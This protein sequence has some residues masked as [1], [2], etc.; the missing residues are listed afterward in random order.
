MRVIMFFAMLLLISSCSRETICEDREITPVFLKFTPADIDTFIVRKY[1]ANSAF[2][3]LLDS[4]IIVFGYSGYYMTHSD[5][6]MVRLGSG[7]LQN[8]FDWQIFIP[9]KNK[10][11][12]ISE[13]SSEKRTEKFNYGFFNTKKIA[14]T[15]DNRIFSI[16]QDNQLVTFNNPDNYFVYINN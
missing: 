7:Q 14:Y 6:T 3:N 11:I 1:A 8:G 9:A 12:N 2:T 5:S 4:S 15:C 13:I 16:K 10:K